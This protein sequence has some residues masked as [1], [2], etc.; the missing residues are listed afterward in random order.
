MLAQ[1]ILAAFALTASAQTVEHRSADGVFA[2]HLA[3]G[4]LGRSQGDTVFAWGVGR[5]VRVSISLSR[6]AFSEN[7][8]FQKTESDAASL[9][10]K[11]RRVDSTQLLKASVPFSLTGFKTTSFGY[12]NAGPNTYSF[13]V[14][15]LTRQKA[16]ELMGTLRDLTP[17]PAAPEPAPVQSAPVPTELPPANGTLSLLNGRLEFPKSTGWRFTPQ[18]D[19]W[20][21][22]E[23]SDW[24]FALSS[25][26]IEDIPL[27][28]KGTIQETAAA[29]FARFE[30]DFVERQGCQASPIDG[31]VLINDWKMMFKTYQCPGMTG[32]RRQVIGILLPTDLPMLGW[33]GDYDRSGSLPLFEKWLSAGNLASQTKAKHGKS[34]KQKT[35]TMLIAVIGGALGFSVM[36]LLMV[37]RRRQKN[38]P[39]E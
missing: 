36:I 1:L 26:V 37:W 38:Q 24:S 29:Y 13:L 28:Q 21:L 27:N 7:A 8:F 17:P 30:L 22:I 14:K 11:G 31:G 2:M 39:S 35:P 4:K 16:A 18:K 23:G 3:G 10:K 6:E 33:T 5:S 9:R 19:G 15:G 25:K 32:E 20:T 12:F 34:G